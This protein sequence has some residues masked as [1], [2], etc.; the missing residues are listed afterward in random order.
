MPA[1]PKL[2]FGYNP[3][4][5]ERGLEPVNP[6]TFTKDLQSVLDVMAPNVNSIWLGDHLMNAERFRLEAWTVLTWI[7]ARYP[8]PMLGT[9]VLAQSFRYPPLLAK[10]VATLQ[11]LSEGRYIFGYGAGW[12]KP[13]YDAY[14]YPYPSA[15][16][17]IEEL[18]DAIRV[19]KALWTQSPATYEGTHY[20]V[21]DA[22]CEPRPDPIPPLMLGG[23]GEKYMLR[24]VAEHADWWLSL[25]RRPE[26]LEQKLAVLAQHCKD[27]GR[28]VSE[29]KK[30]VPIRVFLDRDGKAA[31]NRAGKN[32]EKEHPDFAGDPAELRDYIA[33][34]QAAGFDKVLFLM[35]GF[36]DTADLKLL[37]DEV[38][39]HFA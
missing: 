32:L 20:S 18:D 4:A 28:D 39:P 24:V 11:Y 3:P 6:R 15:R 34:L 25:F 38:L 16:K 22:Y 2:L 37:V 23:D 1:S 17:R 14:G 9:F 5:A 30:C 21:K 19:I 26:V 13:E 33:Q 8:T 7:A 36:P 10:M 31:K 35:A 27:V 29:I 12:D